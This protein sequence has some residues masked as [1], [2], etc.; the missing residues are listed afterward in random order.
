MIVEA[1]VPRGTRLILLSHEFEPNPTNRDEVVWAVAVHR[2]ADGMATLRGHV[3]G[4]D[5][6]CAAGWCFEAQ[7]TVASIRANLDGAR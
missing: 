1:D 5:G 7:V 2:E 6:E 3:C 4:P